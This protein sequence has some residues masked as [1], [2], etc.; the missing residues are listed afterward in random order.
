MLA[1]Q[2]LLDLGMASD[3]ESLQRHL[4]VAAEELG[5]GLVLAV[6]IRG[7]LQS[8]RAW[9][10]SIGNTPPAFIEAQR[11]LDDT[12]RDP[13]MTALHRSVMPVVYD[14]AFYTSAGA[15]DLWDVQAPYDYKCGV[16]C[17]VHQPSHAESFLLGI[18]RAAPVPSD[19]IARMTLVADMQL[20]T[21]YAQSAMQRLLTPEPA[22]APVL[23]QRELECLR[24]ARDGDTVWQ[25]GD[26]LAI[27]SDQV[28]LHQRQAVRKLGAS[29]V[30]GAVL[31]CIQGGLIG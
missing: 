17:S 11:S 7:S 24:R 23:D 29:S 2:Q 30:P 3:L 27:S 6:I 22:G 14:Q 9:V 13:V 19:P 4:V 12:L 28:Q 21:S 31:R 10:K 26:R 25:I 16:A 20:L 18:D 15:G 8:G 1:Q 5:F